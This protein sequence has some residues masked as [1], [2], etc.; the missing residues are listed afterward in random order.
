MIILLIQTDKLKRIRSGNKNL[1]R[2][3]QNFRKKPKLLKE[4]FQRVKMKITKRSSNHKIIMVLKHH[5]LFHPIT[6]I[7]FYFLRTLLKKLTF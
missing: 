4:F 2:K 1:G 6:S 5:S 7:I 3:S